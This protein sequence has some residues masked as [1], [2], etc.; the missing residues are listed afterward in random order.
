MR[1][2]GLRMGFL[3]PLARSGRA[4]RSTPYRFWS[5]LLGK[6]EEAAAFEGFG[7]LGGAF[8]GGVRKSCAFWVR[9]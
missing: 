8:H 7:P 1:G 5:A 3:T 6:G 4:W 9:L 2:L